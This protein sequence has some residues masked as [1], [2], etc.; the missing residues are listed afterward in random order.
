MYDMSDGVER[1]I[2]PGDRGEFSDPAAKT[3]HKNALAVDNFLRTAFNRDGWDGKGSPLHVVVHAKTED[4]A[5]LINATWDLENQRIHLGDGDGQLL[6]PLGNSLDVM[7][8][9]T[10]HAVV[11]SEVKLDYEGQ[12]GGINESWADVIGALADPDD[13][14]IGEDEMT[15]GIPGDAIRDLSAP[16]YSHLNDVPPGVDDVHDLSGI[17]SLAAVRVAD[18]VGR[19]EMGQIWYRALVDH[20]A[21]RAGFSGA[22][23]ATLLAAKDLFGEK[24]SQ[25]N[26]VQDAWKSVGVQAEWKPIAK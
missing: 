6:G 2:Q 20:M 25:F 18:K 1:P 5:P 16:R 21:D 12:S 17:P 19:P 26:A 4:G 22:A 13:W 11:D 8:H 3:A 15:P 7:M 10:S 23:T 14:L 9:E 24:S